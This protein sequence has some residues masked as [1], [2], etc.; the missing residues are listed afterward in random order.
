MYG[1]IFLIRELLKPSIPGADLILAS[2]IDL[3]NSS[4]VR[5][6]SR[7]SDSTCVS[8]ELFTI[9]ELHIFSPRN[10]SIDILALLLTGFL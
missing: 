8:L 9:G 5:G 3:S 7:A 10:S 2:L 4:T 6:D 1:Q